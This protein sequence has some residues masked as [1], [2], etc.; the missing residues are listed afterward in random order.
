[1]FE[2]YAECPACGVRLEVGIPAERLLGHPGAGGPGA[3]LLEAGGFS[4]EFR[5]P[6]TRDL[7][8]LESSGGGAE[9][10]ASA[11][12]TSASDANGPVD[13]GQ[14]P[15]EVLEPLAARMLESDP[16]AEI[17]VDLE[18]E[19][20]GRRWPMLLDL[21]SF[22]WKEISAR[23]RRLLLEVDALARSY[24]WAE[25]DILAM[26]GFRRQCYLELLGP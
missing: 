24:G 8:E 25:R 11:C 2:A 22:L 12:V 5:A 19:G 4:I 20:C 9:A 21:P 7:L 6:S 10:L 3:G 23:A 1:V 18:C 13:P 15:K 17:Q 14:L 16:L 26:S